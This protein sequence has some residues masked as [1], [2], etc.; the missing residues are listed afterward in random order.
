MVEKKPE[1]H[2]W[3]AWTLMFA[4]GAAVNSNPET[5]FAMICQV[6]ALFL[7]AA[8][9]GEL[10]QENAKWRAWKAHQ[11]DP[12]RV[13]SSDISPETGSAP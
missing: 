8:S 7:C 13:Q 12:A 9:G 4:I 6:L 10:A 11:A 2:V 5:P 1:P 3:A